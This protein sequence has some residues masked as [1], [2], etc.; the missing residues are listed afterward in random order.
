[1]VKKTYKRPEMTAA[2]CPEEII[3][4]PDEALDKVS[5]GKTREEKLREKIA[6]FENMIAT[7]DPRYLKNR[8]FYDEAIADMKRQLYD[9]P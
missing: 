1:M 9:N 7:N 4:L 6:F 8:D 2:L 3:A 5:G